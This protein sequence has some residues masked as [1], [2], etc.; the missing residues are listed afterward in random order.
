MLVSL[1]LAIA[2][3]AALYS[4]IGDIA[5]YRRLS[6]VPIPIEVGDVQ[7]ERAR[8]QFQRT[9]NAMAAR[10]VVK[11]ALTIL[12]ASCAFATTLVFVH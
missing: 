12:L 10:I 2:L 7:F 11:S 9:L 4:L 5:T 6:S 3:L 8:V 1:I